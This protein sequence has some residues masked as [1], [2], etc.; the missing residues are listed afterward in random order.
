MR[1]ELAEAFNLIA[2]TCARTPMSWPEHITV[3]KALETIHRGLEERENDESL[4][5]PFK[6]VPKPTKTDA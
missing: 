6:V 3:Q 4:L 2:Q 5:A 1:H